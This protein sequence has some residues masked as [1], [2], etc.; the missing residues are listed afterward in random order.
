MPFES[1]RHI[2]E[3]E[4]LPAEQVPDNPGKKNSIVDVKCKDNFKRL[5]IVEMQM[6]WDEVFMNRIVFNA[7]KAYIRQLGRS[8]DYSLLQPVYTLALL[9]E[10]FDN[11]TDKF[12][13][14]FQIV[15][16]EN[17]NEIIPCLEFVLIELTGKFRP[18]TVTD[19]KLMAL[20]LRFL[21]EVNEDMKALPAEMQENEH[22]RQ[23]AELCEEG[24]FTTEELAAYDKYW[25]IIRT[26]KT[27]WV[28]ALQKGKI[29]GKMEGK[30]EIAM[31]ALEMGMSIEDASKLTGLSEEQIEELSKH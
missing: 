30:M 19:R 3:I 20:W 1:G 6:D 11:K 2:V 18:E 4:Y 15:N 16:C 28:S 27:R 13:H 24:A 17:T 29:E 7:G 26:E 8:Q 22:I 23:A 5:F 31:K 10:N 9:N 25:D 12:Y 21:K 14:H